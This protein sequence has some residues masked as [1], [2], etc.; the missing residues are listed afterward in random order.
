MNQRSSGLLWLVLLGVIVFYGPQL[1]LMLRNSLTQ[2]FSTLAPL[3]VPVLGIIAV[4]L[5]VR[6]YWNRY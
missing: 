1:A 5:V 2:M 3:V 4:T 6:M